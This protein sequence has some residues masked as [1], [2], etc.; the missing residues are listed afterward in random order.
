ENSRLIKMTPLNQSK[1]K[2]EFAQ[3][4]PTVVSFLETLFVPDI[5]L[6]ELASNLIENSTWYKI[7]D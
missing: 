4:L 3:K 2:Q 5:D 6:P 1:A 7:M